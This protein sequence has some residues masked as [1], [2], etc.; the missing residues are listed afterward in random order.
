MNRPKKLKR[1]S[2]LLIS[3]ARPEARGDRPKASLEE[4]GPA[5]RGEP[6]GLVPQRALG[7]P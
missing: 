4:G 7:D 6:T 3:K 5:L 1:T 2:E